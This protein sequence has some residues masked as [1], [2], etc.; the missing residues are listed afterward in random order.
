MRSLRIRAYAK[1]NLGL[2]VTGRRPDGYHE[3]DTIFQSI[4]LADELVLERRSDGQVMLTMEPDLGIP[5][6]QNLVFQAV[7]LLQDPLQMELGVHIHLIK[8]IPVGAGL[9]GGSSDAAAAL[10]GVNTLF[11]LGLSKSK[12]KTLGAELGSDVPFFFEG[13]RCRAHG[14]GEILTT[15]SG[16]PAPSTIT[17]LIAPFSLSTKGVYAAL[18]QLEPSAEL[19]TAPYPNDLEAVALR[20]H[21]ELRIYRAYLERASVGFGLSGSGPTYYALFEDEPSARLFSRS[22]EAELR[23]QT[24]LC[25]SVS[26]GYE[27]LNP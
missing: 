8:R 7:H 15:L 19:L 24:F 4:D 27:I 5:M 21:P 13:G 14:R 16:S 23:C 26:M 2:R 25:K 18:D 3:I 11:E 22:A 6:E 10:G 20:M 1:I 9:G 12:L 17:L